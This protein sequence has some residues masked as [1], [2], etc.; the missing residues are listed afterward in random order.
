MCGDSSFSRTGRSDLPVISTEAYLNQSHNAEDLGVNWIY[1]SKCAGKLVA[2]EQTTPSEPGQQVGVNVINSLTSE[3]FNETAICSV[4]GN[5]SA[6]FNSGTTT[7]TNSATVDKLNNFQ[8]EF[9]AAGMSYK[10]SETNSLQLLATVT[11]TDYTDRSGLISARS[12]ANKITQD[13]IN[14]SYTKDIN[15]N[16]S[17]VASI[18]VEGTRPGGFRLTYPTGFEPQ[19]SLAVTW[20]ITPKL[21][22]SPS[23]SRI[24]TPPTAIIANLQVTES[25]NL[26]L[27]YQLTPKISL[28]TSVSASR[29]TGAVTQSGLTG[30][31]LATGQNE[32]GYAARANL[33]YAMTPFLAAILSYQY[34][35]TIQTG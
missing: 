10:V 5:Y 13:Q 7:S 20:L 34:N 12:L 9:I 25:A 8:S 27:S 28:S 4:T 35:R 6:I 19:Y 3:S 11:G 18:G 2:A 26:G 1:T 16:L 17:L 22:L 23:V 29:I 24:A 31:I 15:P 14:L 33:T 32:H 30:A 21:T